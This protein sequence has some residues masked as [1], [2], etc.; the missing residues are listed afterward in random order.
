M[1]KLESNISQ[2][3]P[4]VLTQKVFRDAIISKRENNVILNKATTL[5]RT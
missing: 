1:E 5:L 4:Q 2:Y 3:F